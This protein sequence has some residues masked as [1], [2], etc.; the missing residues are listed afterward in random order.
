MVERLYIIPAF[1][2]W[3]RL[4][5]GTVS[6]SCFL[7]IENKPVRGGRE[8]ER[9]AKRKHGGEGDISRGFRLSLWNSPL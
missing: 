2:K 6:F 7:F 5:I 4:D 3:Q 1:K 9:P 8:T